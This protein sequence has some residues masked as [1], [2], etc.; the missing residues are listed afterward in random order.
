MLI[1][2]YHQNIFPHSFIHFC[3]FES[4]S[5]GSSGCLETH[6]GDQADLESHRS[7]CL[8]LPRTEIKGELHCVHQEK[9]L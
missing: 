3:Y 2:H 7:T 1:I 6:Y 8:R 4:G 5:L 9:A